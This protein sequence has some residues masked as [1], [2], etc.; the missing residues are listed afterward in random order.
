MN[1]AYRNQHAKAEQYFQDLVEHAPSNVAFQSN[2][3]LIQRWREKPLDAEHTVS[4]WNGMTPISQTTQI[5]QMQNAQML[6]KL[7]VGVPL[8]SIYTKP[9]LMILRCNVAAKS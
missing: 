5:N 4:Q 7:S 9:Y 3:A 8:I 1:Y 2:L 6:V